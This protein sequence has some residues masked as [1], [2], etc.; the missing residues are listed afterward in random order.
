MWV[1]VLGLLAAV[2]PF[3]LF[4]F[5]GTGIATFLLVAA[6]MLVGSIGVHI[7]TG[8]QGE[9]FAFLLIPFCILGGSGLLIPYLEGAMLPESGAALT[10]CLLAWIIPM[11]YACIFTWAEGS[12]AIDDFARFYKRTSVL[13]YIVYFCILIYEVVFRYQGTVTESRMQLIPFATFAAYVEGFLTGVVSPDRILG[14]VLTRVALFLPYGFFVAMICRKL[15]GLLRLFLLIFL[16]FFVEILQYVFRWGAC[17]MDDA[18][19]A[20]LGALI[21]MVGF[22]LFNMLFQQF[23]GK[24]FDASE[25]DR[26][27]YGRKI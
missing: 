2:I 17:D 5:M 20:I 22:F 27:Y 15:H 11:A 7:L 14:F 26:D 25:V 21:G 1:V 19:F 10:G 8:E 4:Y 16:P 24:N 23:T 18:V 12:L 13:F 9:L 3:A 6:V